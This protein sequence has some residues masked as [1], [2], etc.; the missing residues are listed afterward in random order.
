[1]DD[2]RLALD[3][4]CFALIGQGKTN[5]DLHL[6]YLLGDAGLVIN[7]RIGAQPDAGSPELGELSSQILTALVDE[8]ELWN[9]PDGGHFSL[10]KRP[11]APAQ[12]NGEGRRAPAQENGEG[13]RAPAQEHGGGRRAPASET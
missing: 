8:H 7:G 9:G 6:E 12:E 13:R 3:E 11:S 1:V 4:L 5:E 10:T 2:L